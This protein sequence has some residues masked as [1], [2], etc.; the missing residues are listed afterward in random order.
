MLRNVGAG[1]SEREYLFDTNIFMPRPKNER[2]RT[3]IERSRTRIERSRNALFKN[4][5]SALYKALL[6]VI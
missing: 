4:S 6:K 5:T 3:C 2:S 1:Y